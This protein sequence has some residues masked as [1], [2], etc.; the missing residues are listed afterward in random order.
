MPPDEVG[1]RVA[2][3]MWESA[4]DFK[5]VVLPFIRGLLPPGEFIGLED[6]PRPRALE[7]VDQVA[8]IDVWYVTGMTRLQGIASRIQYGGEPFESF[9]IRARLPS[10]APTELG[11]RLEALRSHGEH[12]VAPH[13][14]VQAWVE[15]PR[16]GRF[17]M[18]MIVRTEDLFE[19]V[20]EHPEKVERR[21][22]PQDGSEFLVVWAADLRPGT[23]SIRVA[24]SSA[25]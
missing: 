6:L 15:R 24:P 12:L 16:T 14:T 22:N 5:R 4:F 19:F 3:A 7:V 13:C 9:T 23:R 11:K 10:G 8:G 18:A 20:S 21:A 17:V 25:W 1:Q 2:E